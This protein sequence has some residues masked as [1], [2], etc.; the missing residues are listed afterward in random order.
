LDV[1]DPDNI[2]LPAMTARVNINTADKNDA[3]VVP[4][5]TLKADSSG[6]YVMVK[7]ENG[8]QEKRYVKVGIYSDE[9]VEILSGLS[10]GESVISSY[11]AA[12]KSNSAAN[13]GNMPRRAPHM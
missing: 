7:G 13:K 3:L 11:K 5:S 12:E 1:E 10:E 2:L 4:I 8:E 9:N 6:N